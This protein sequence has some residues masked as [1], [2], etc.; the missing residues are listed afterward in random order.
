MR[1]AIA[2]TKG[3][4]GKTTSSIYLAAAAA[5]RGLSATVFD[6]DPQGTATAWADN[7]VEDGEAVQWKTVPVNLHQLKRLAFPEADLEIIDCPPADPEVVNT[8]IKQADLLIVPTRATGVDLDRVWATVDNLGGARAK[9]LIVAAR[10]GTSLLAETFSALDDEDVPYF[11]APIPL[12]EAIAG[13][14]NTAPQEFHGYEDVL[15]E[16]LAN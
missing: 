3:G 11:Q 5:A 8:A 13:A 15:D 9:V 1:V 10:F 12:R 4:V 14:W 7:A 6:A 16:L 2:N